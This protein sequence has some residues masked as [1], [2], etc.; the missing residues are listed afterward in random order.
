M[1]QTKYNTFCPLFPGFYGTV[2]EYDNEGQDIESYNEEFGSIFD[3]EDF[4]FD[5]ADYR[6][7]VSKAFVNRLETELN[8]ILPVKIEFQELYSP[9]EYNFSNDAI[10]VSVELNLNVL[11]AHIKALLD[12]LCNIQ[13]E[14]NCTDDETCYW[15]DSEYWI[16]FTQNEQ[17]QPIY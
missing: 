5:Y 3:Y 10:N 17:P 2:F 15:A 9:K 11:L 7:R 12:C 1:K 4:T 8:S 14:F 13:Q 16:D 6:T